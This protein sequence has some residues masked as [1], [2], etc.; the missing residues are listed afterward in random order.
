MPSQRSTAGDRQAFSPPPASNSVTSVTRSLPGA[1]ARKPCLLRAFGGTF[2]GLPSGS[3][4][5]EPNLPP[6]RAPQGTRPSL[7]MED[8]TSRS[9]ARMGAR[10]SAP[11]A[12]DSLTRR[13]P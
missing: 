2:S 8:G 12:I 10:P 13:Q 9:D 11:V 4:A 5:Q 7:R 1:E 3:P 6:A